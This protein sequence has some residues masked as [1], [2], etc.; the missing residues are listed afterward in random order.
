MS[1]AHLQSGKMGTAAEQL[2]GMQGDKLQATVVLPVLNARSQ[3]EGL[4]QR[5]R[6]QEYPRDAWELVVVDNGSTDGT[7]EVLREIRDPWIR[8][9]QETKRG[10]SAARNCG[11]RHARAHIVVFIDS[12][13]VPQRNWLSQMV[14]VF[15]DRSIWAAGGIVV[16]APPESLTEAFTA[17]QKLLNQEDFFKPMRYKPPF[18][19]TAN[20]AARRAVFGRVGGFDE[21]LLVGEDADFCWRLLQAGGRLH[22]T[23]E[24]IVEH[25]H[26]SSPLR[27]A[28]QMFNYGVGSVAV[29]SKHRDFIAQSFWL[30]GRSYFCLG[31]AIIKALLY[32]IFRRDPYMRYEGALEVVRFSC[33]LFGRLIGS[34]KYRILVI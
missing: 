8:V 11:V 2:P 29:F 32:P 16:S 20:F 24:A 3:I 14:S 6:Q 4:L 15:G 17:K 9:V 23:P 34:L 31:K 21:S 26:R 18:L 5:L 7:W 13:C 1:E 10:P 27:F 22:L 19:L 25:R 33:F 28:R 12:D 30:D